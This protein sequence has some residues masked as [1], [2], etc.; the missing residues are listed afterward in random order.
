M[1]GGLELAWE[2]GFRR[3]A[4]GGASSTALDS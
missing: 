4:R 1:R 3:G 2:L